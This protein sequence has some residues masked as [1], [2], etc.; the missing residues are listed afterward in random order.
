MPYK[1]QYSKYMNKLVKW[2]K[3]NKKSP[4]VVTRLYE[5]RITELT[6]ALDENRLSLENI[7]SGKLPANED[8]FM[9]RYWDISK[10]K[11]K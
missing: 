10:I 4:A 7:P 1:S 9:P 5:R 11:K 3:K 2:A 6:A 8:V